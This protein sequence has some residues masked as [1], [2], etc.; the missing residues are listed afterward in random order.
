MLFNN[1]QNPITKD[2]DETAIN[3]IVFNYNTFNLCSI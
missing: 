2:N 3:C 1:H